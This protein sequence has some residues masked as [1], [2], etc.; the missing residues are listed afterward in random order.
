METFT[1][2]IG[3]QVLSVS[4][5]RLRDAT[6]ST[7]NASAQDNHTTTTTS[8]AELAPDIWMRDKEAIVEKI[9][10]KLKHDEG[11]LSV[12]VDRVKHELKKDERLRSSV[13]V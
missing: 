2:W 9:V 3:E 12:I 11:F 5:G 10:E 1:Q 13:E 7:P 8:A 4:N 6:G